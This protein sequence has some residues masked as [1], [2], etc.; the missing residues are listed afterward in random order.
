MKILWLLAVF[1]CMGC[2]TQRVEPETRIEVEIT[3]AQ[4][5]ALSPSVRRLLEE[6]ES[7]RAAGELAATYSDAMKQAEKVYERERYTRY[8][9]WVIPDAEPEGRPVI[10]VD[11]DKKSGRIVLCGTFVP[12][13]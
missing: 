6:I 8:L 11:V 9:F 13:W 7:H 5:E 12:V 3:P 4:R 1:V 2:E 10:M